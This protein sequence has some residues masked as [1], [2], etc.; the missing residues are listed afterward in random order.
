M[1][2]YEDY[3]IPSFLNGPTRAIPAP[4]MVEVPRSGTIFINTKDEDFSAIPVAMNVS[5]TVN[6]EQGVEFRRFLTDLDADD[7][8]TFRKAVFQENG[9]VNR[10]FRIVS[11]QPNFTQVGSDT[12]T[13]TF[14]IF[15]DEFNR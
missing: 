9:I 7:D 5:V 13:A 2:I 14:T 11:G 10:E 6:G 1:I 3:N 8:R 4:N 12:W 15:A